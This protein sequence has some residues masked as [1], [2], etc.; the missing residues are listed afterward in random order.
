MR[1]AQTATAT[2]NVADAMMPTGLTL[3]GEF[4]TPARNLAA[5]TRSCL[6]EWF[7]HDHSWSQ[8][9]PLLPFGWIGRAL[10]Y[11]Y[12]QRGSNH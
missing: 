2:N 3:P 5:W 9:Q 10:L 8:L 1:E 6:C 12:I 11:L 4:Y 7:H